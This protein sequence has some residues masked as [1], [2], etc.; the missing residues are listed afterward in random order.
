MEIQ[1]HKPQESNPAGYRPGGRSISPVYRTGFRPDL[2]NDQEGSALSEYWQILTRR[3]FTILLIV[4]CTTML[5]V[6]AFF[7]Q[8][9]VYQART[10]L[11]I[12]GINEN[13]L[14]LK[15]IDPTA[16]SSN[17]AAD[18]YLQTQIHVIQSRHLIGRVVDKLKLSEIKQDHS[19]DWSK[20]LGRR[21]PENVPARELQTQAVWDHLTVR[22]PKQTRIVEILYDSPD[23]NQAAAIASA[24]ANEFIQYRQELR[25]TS[26]QRTG[27]WLMRQ[28]EDLRRKLE[29]SES[30]LNSYAAKYDLV[31]TQ[32]KNNLAEAK[33]QQLQEE[34]SRAEAER[35][36]RQS[37]IEAT[38]ST[39]L[40]S[41]P[42]ALDDTTL[43]DYRLKIA[44]LRRELAELNATLTPAHYKVQRVQAQIVE[45]QAT[46]EKEREQLYNRLRKDFDAAK[47]RETLLASAYGQQAKLVSEQGNRLVRYN[48]L[49]R[50]VDSTRQLYD[51]LL[52]RVREAGVAAAMSASNIL[53]VDPAEVPSEPYKPSKRM[54]AAL[55]LLG[56]LAFAIVFVLFRESR[57]RSIYAPGHAAYY[58]D[59]P[60]LGT[61]PFC[62]ESLRGRAFSSS[63]ARGGSLSLTAGDRTPA[64]TAV[65]A[66]LLAARSN[67]PFAES[68]RILLNALLFP[69]L[70]SSNPR[71][72][73]VTSCNPE[74]GKTTVVTQLAL[75]AAEAG[76]RVLLIDGD[77]RRP[78]LHDIFQVSNAIGFSDLLQS[79]SD[80]ETV[81]EGAIHALQSSGLHVM[82]AG[83][84]T[85]N[86]S[87]LLYSAFLPILL[88]R[89]RSEFDLIL[90]DS[91]PMLQLADARVL[92]RAVET[93]VLVL[94]AGKTTR[95]TAHAARQSLAEDGTPLLG[96]V[97]N[98]WDSKRY[99][100]YG[101]TGPYPKQSAS[102]GW[103]FEP[104]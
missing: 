102:A 103:E 101:Y 47:R 25:W 68:F 43:R 51:S 89:L 67:E 87:R 59:T 11:E 40:D 31:F 60:E 97:L 14:N 53:V 12:Q 2:F 66:S 96:T 49:K 22:A 81:P 61:I 55:G 99:P 82:T 44:E 33:L 46:F 86:I 42:E 95:E 90:I 34:L 79:L 100:S 35:V 20:L 85:A 71:T 1:I 18:E 94:R 84:K 78:R 50:E 52:Q 13:F 21:A 6:G 24:L 27:Q 63:R 23:P 37:R 17:Y 80:S 91:P 70:D 38:Q 39:S 64:T 75:A 93:V 32:E 54:N 41:L 10:S 62:K 69:R 5:S 57:D 7:L 98:R 9:P 45:L 26:N 16:S 15:E 104:S 72:V 58:L 29:S 30:E 8:A 74:E 76:R 4:V 77:L 92:G 28:L 48:T 83:T 56:G 19:Y 3:K 65:P 36:A 88:R 73:L